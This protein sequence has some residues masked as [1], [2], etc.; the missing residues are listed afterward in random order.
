MLQD[1]YQIITKNEQKRCK[2]KKDEFHFSVIHRSV[3]AKLTCR[4]GRHLLCTRPIAFILQCYV[5]LGPNIGSKVL[6]NLKIW[7]R[8]REASATCWWHAFRHVRIRAFAGWL[9]GHWWGFISRNYV[10]WPTFLL[11]N[12]FIA[13]KGS[14]FWFLLYFSSTA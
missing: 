9:Q 10:V 1:I 7:N 13:L 5:F 3:N 11:M 6:R 8:K 2:N 14:H 4:P 12:V